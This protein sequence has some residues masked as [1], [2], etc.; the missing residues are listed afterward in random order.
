MGNV[1]KFIQ[2]DGRDTRNRWELRKISLPIIIVITNIDIEGLVIFIVQSKIH[3]KSVTNIRYTLSKVLPV[4][5]DKKLR[6]GRLEL[7]VYSYIRSSKVKG[8]LK[9]SGKCIA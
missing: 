7:H 6:K 8:G 3:K 9:N 1:E 2:L 5:L 4:N